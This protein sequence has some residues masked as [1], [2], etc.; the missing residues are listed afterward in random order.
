ML[1]TSIPALI[2]G[3][4]IIET[5]K[6]CLT[7]MQHVGPDEEGAMQAQ[8]MQQYN[9]AFTAVSNE[10]NNTDRSVST[11]SGKHILRWIKPRDS[12]SM[13]QQH[14]WVTGP[15]ETNELQ[16]ME[17]TRLR[18]MAVGHERATAENLKIIRTIA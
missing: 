5:P 2:A 11:T 7:R 6:N 3:E 14:R 4:G 8:T 15:T 16:L 12:Q 13:L 9:A 18:D 1:I 17:L 10:L